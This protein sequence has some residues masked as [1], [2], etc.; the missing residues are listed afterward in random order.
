MKIA[1]CL[2]GQPRDVL[3][4]YSIIKEYIDK[5]S[6]VQVDFFCHTWFSSDQNHVYKV[7]SYRNIQPVQQKSD[8][9]TTINTVYKPIEHYV[10]EPIDFDISDILS[11]RM[12]DIIPNK[13]LQNIKNTRSN[14][15]SQTKVRDILFEHVK[16]SSAD[17]G[18]FLNAIQVIDGLLTFSF[19]TPEG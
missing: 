19:E 7:S 1:W 17:S 3:A 11:S 15:Y 5:H 9:I 10:Q 16:N 4:G 12:V 2:R 14:I 13:I 18:F 8:T 6:T